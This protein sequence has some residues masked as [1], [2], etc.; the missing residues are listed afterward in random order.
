[1]NK[2]RNLNLFLILF[3]FLSACA[4][5]TPA[6]VTQRVEVTRLVPMTVEVTRQVTQVPTATS[7]ATPTRA[8]TSTAAPTPEPAI[9]YPISG[10][11]P[12]R[13]HVGD[14]A[15]VTLDGG[16]NAIRFSEDLDTPGNIVGYA[17]AGMRIYIIEG[18][19]CNNGWLV[20]K[21]QNMQG[22]EGFTPESSPE[23]FFLAPIQ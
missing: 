9:Y 19:W 18:P 10:C 11:S 22:G 21:V 15:M 17:P 23:A 2:K 16:D 5:P 20:W 13:L 3:V 6:V 8:P 1:M 12:S 4:T 14:L 7:A